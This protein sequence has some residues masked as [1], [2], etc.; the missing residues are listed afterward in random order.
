MRIVVNIVTMAV[1]LVAGCALSQESSSR[2]GYDFTGVDKVAI[3]A[4]EGAVTSE[5]AK[6]QIADFFSMELLDKG[7][8]PVGRAQV[9]AQLRELEPESDGLITSET[10]V[11]VGLILD[12]PAVLA[13]RI[14]HF[15]EEIS[16]TAQMISVED[17]STLWLASGSGQGKRTLSNV[18]GFGSKGKSD[19]QL[20]GSVMAGPSPLGGA[21]GVP[22]T[23]EEAEKAQA[24]VRS[25]CRSLPTQTRSE[26]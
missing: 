8:A 9:R 3:V 25:M 24:I 26:W 21:G 18:F 17:G 4:V 6:D 16:I 23:P 7:Y 5:A 11:Q 13:I 20:M 14:P 22:L 15:A 10:A 12:V 2:I 19:N 1:L